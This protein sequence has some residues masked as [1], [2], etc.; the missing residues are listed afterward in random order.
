MVNTN[1]NYPKTTNCSTCK[2]F[3]CICNTSQQ[4]DNLDNNVNIFNSTNEDIEIFPPSPS[5][6]S[7]RTDIKP[8]HVLLNLEVV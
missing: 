8:M 4:N 6:I 2:N 1:K 7:N 5:D 3:P